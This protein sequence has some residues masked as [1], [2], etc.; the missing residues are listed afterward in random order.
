MSTPFLSLDTLGPLGRARAAGGAVNPVSPPA[1]SARRA[2]SAPALP[3][4][5]RSPRRAT[6][7]A[8]M[9][10]VHVVVLFG[11]LNAQRVR[12]VV[13]ESAPIFLS[14]VSAPTP[15]APSTPLPPPA[16]TLPKIVAPPLPLIAETPSPSPLMAAPA[17]PAPPA[18]A[19][20]PEAPPAPA[21]APVAAPVAKTIP[22]ASVQYLVAPRPAYSRASARMRESGRA[23]VRV[24]IDEAG[25]P[26]D[27]QIATSS[28]FA[29]L[30]DAAV[31]AVRGARF[32]PYLENG[33]A[34]AGWAFVPIE[35]ELDK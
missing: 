16:Q 30:D 5:T 31:D 24:W 4:P 35:F 7:V 1:P 2:M 10:V 8:V 21:A 27:V 13:H 34:M 23:L 25:M 15:P 20:H 33:A 18:P 19:V 11:L 17:S 29:R 9:L 12:D 28:G 3:L 22:A 14:V 6:A 26:R 32:K